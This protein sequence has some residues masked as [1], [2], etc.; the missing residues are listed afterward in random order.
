MI[1]DEFYSNPYFTTAFPHFKDKVDPQEPKE[2]A[3]SWSESLMHRYKP[4]PWSQEQWYQYAEQTFVEG[5]RTPRGPLKWMSD[6]DKEKVHI[7]IDYEMGKLE[8]TGLSRE[9]VLYKKPTGVPLGSD[10]MFQFLKKNRDAREM[11]IKPGE[12][13]TVEKVLDKALRQDIDVDRSKTLY[14]KRY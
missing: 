7:Q 3:H 1:E 5:Y 8:D 4:Q 13:F 10:P 12:E 9:E 14:D 2:A 11:L 6:E